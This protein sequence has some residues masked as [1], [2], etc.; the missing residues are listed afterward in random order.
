[1]AEEVLGAIRIVAAYAG[2]AK[3]VQR[4][5]E[6]LKTARKVGVQKGL[7]SGLGQGLVWIIAFGVIGLAFWY[8]GELVRREDLVY[9]AGVVLQVMTNSTLCKKSIFHEFFVFSRFNS[10]CS[11]E[12][13]TS[14][15]QS[16]R[17]NR[18]QPREAPQSASSE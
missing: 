13:E 16:V 15:G 18:F 5:E 11:L 14:A 4:Y 7:V 1:M 17:W 12:C 2:E 9:T 10:Q 3:E 8:G 6:N